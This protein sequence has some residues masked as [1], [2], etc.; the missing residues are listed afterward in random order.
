MADMASQIV[1]TNGL[2]DGKFSKVCC[3]FLYFFLDKFCCFI[4]QKAEKL[5]H[6]QLLLAVLNIY[7]SIVSVCCTK[8]LHQYSFIKTP[9]PTQNCID[10]VCC[11]LP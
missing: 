11:Y 2:S 5:L 10:I 3:L 9:I 6:L 4:T 7:I 1:E 8:H